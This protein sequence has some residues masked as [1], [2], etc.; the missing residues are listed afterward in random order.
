MCWCCHFCVIQIIDAEAIIVIVYR[1][2]SCTFAAFYLCSNINAVT[3]ENES[4]DSMV[5]IV[6]VLWA[7]SWQ[8]QEILLCSVITRPALRLTEPPIQ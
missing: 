6:T 1:L 7:K 5:I 2:C 8:G 3:V 4:W